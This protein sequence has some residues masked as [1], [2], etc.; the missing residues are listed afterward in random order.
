MI[1]IL[2]RISVKILCAVMIIGL[3]IFAGCKEESTEKTGNAT[4]TKENSV[5]TT[6]DAIPESGTLKAPKITLKDE[7]LIE[8]I[9][10]PG[11]FKLFYSHGGIC[12]PC[13]EMISRFNSVIK[14]QHGADIEFHHFVSQDIKKEIEELGLSK[15][16]SSG[17]MI[18]FD[19]NNKAVWQMFNPRFEDVVEGLK[20]AGFTKQITKPDLLPDF[21]DPFLGDD[22]DDEEDKEDE[23]TKPDKPATDDDDNSDETNNPNDSGNSE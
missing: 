16:E 22:D 5:K 11:K 13:M 2:M 1:T 10:K 21:Y 9:G 20:V 14:N 18:V 15:I 17:T 3:L 6:D 19:R 23:E 8:L 4:D 7:K 12:V